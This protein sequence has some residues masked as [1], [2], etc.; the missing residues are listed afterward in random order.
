MDSGHGDARAMDTSSSGAV[1]QSKRVADTGLTVVHQPEDTEPIVDIIIIH[2]LQGHPFD[3]WAA[4]ASSGDPSKP[5]KL[6]AQARALFSKKAKEKTPDSSSATSTQRVF[7]PRDLLPNDCPKARILVFGYDTIVAK[8]QLAGAAN[9]NSIFAHS[10]DLINEL[11]R[12]RPLGRPAIFVT[13]SLGGIL[14]KETLAMCSTSNEEDVQD[15]L[16][17]TVGVVFMGTPHRGSSA[18]GIGEIARKVASLLLM[19]TNAL[20]LDSLAL[21]NSDLVRSQEIFSSLWHKHGFSVKTFQEG[22]PLRVPFKIGQSKMVKVV[23]DESSCLG[24]SRERAETL[25]GDHRSICRFSTSDDRN[26]RRLAAY[27][28]NQCSNLLTEAQRMQPSKELPQKFSDAGVPLLQDPLTRANQRKLDLL[29]YKG[30]LIRQISITAPAKNTCQWLLQTADDFQTWLTRTDI[31]KHF[32]LLQ[33]TG[34]PGSG[35]STLMKETLE[36]IRSR[37]HPDTG[38]CVIGHFFNRRG[39]PT[40]HS[41][42]GMFR[43][44]LFQLCT[45]HPMCLDS[46]KGLEVDFLASSDSEPSSPDSSTFEFRDFDSRVLDFRVLAQILERIMQSAFAPKA[47][48]ILIDALDECDPEE[49]S[50]VGYFLAGLARDAFAARVCLNICISKREHPSIT[51]NKSLEIRMEN[52]NSPDI[53]RYVH[54]RLELAG[55]SAEEFAQ[56]EDAVV[57]RSSSIF[58][59]AVL[60]ADRVLKDLENGINTRQ[61]LNR[62]NTLPKALEDLFAEILKEV[63]GEDLEVTLRL[64]QWAILAIDRLR[65]REWHHVLAV[66]REVPPPSLKA[67]ASSEFYTETDVQLERQIRSL[68]KGL[69]EVHSPSMNP[70]DKSG[71]A[72][73]D[74][75]SD[76]PG[77]GSL[78]SNTGDT[79]FVQAIHESVGEFFINNRAN[80]LFGKPDSYDFA[81]EG[82][83][84]IMQSCLMYINISEFDDLVSARE[85]A[86]RRLRRRGSATSFMSSASSHSRSRLHDRGSVLGHRP[87]R[88]ETDSEDGLTASSEPHDNDDMIVP[89]LSVLQPLTASEPNRTPMPDR[90]LAILLPRHDQAKRF[91]I[92][93]PEHDSRRISAKLTSHRDQVFSGYQRFEF[94][95]KAGTTRKGFTTIVAH[96]G[97]SR[98]QQYLSTRVFDT[99]DSWSTPEFSKSRSHSMSHLPRVCKV[100]ARADHGL[101][102]T[103]SATQTDRLRPAKTSFIRIRGTRSKGA[104]DLLLLPQTVNEQKWYG[105]VVLDTFYLWR[106]MGN[107]NQAARQSLTL[108]R[109]DYREETIAYI[110]PLETSGS[111]E[112]TDNGQGW[113]TSA[114]MTI[115]QPSDNGVADSHQVLTEA[116]DQ[117]RP[118]HLIT[119]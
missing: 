9:K 86:S 50:E 45:F 61:L 105:F 104:F 93:H 109:D 42:Q 34:K 35:K 75:S 15:I 65:V 114:E 76:L 110:R 21:K 112:A 117:P 31:D 18:A 107:W 30:M 2:G 102:R 40:E 71:D 66:I 64:F 108:A 51:V 85:L 43:S 33:I 80:G 29:K 119:H 27:L 97:A 24:D 89:Q 16:K 82:H 3:T 52:Y 23:P 84:V 49:A 37:H 53:R 83:L 6:K 47:T 59:W 55:A 118:F 38:T 100:A 70:P 106:R 44:I 73:E 39:S 103:L 113:I 12:H 81:S 77:A 116:W 91:L 87:S 41:A 17:S 14:I 56:I 63:Q 10:R 78:D 36:T 8:H 28:I 13:H 95:P 20:I 62:I 92:R 5:S 32:G 69:I 11:C 4:E 58:L 79:R 1:P 74:I 99:N 96:F 67:W 90:E 72:H 26:Y 111:L 54:R 98:R 60:A 25:H 7:W 19:D 88:A 48:F 57:T 94:C 68:S 115:C 46:F 101:R 22:L